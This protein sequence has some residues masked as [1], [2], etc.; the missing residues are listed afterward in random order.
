MSEIR[1]CPECDSCDITPLQPQKPAG[2][3]END[4]RLRWWCCACD[5]RFVSPRI[6]QPKNPGG[7]RNGLS[8]AL[9]EADPDEWP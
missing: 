5:H 7:G 8:R 3:S 4:P 2:R 1:A 6:R 9:V